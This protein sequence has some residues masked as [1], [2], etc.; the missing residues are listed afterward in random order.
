MGSI[1]E[2]KKDM[3]HGNAQAVRYKSYG[4]KLGYSIFHWITK[5]F[6]LKWAYSL[7]L[8]VVP[9]YVLFR[10]DIYQR[11]KP[12]LKRRFPHD[13]FIVRY[14]R[15]FKYIFVFG[16]NLVDQ[17]AI[18]L[19]GVSS[20]ELVFEHEEEVLELLEHRPV[21]FLMSHVGFWEASMA[22][23]IRFKKKMNVMVS[24]AFDKDKRKSFYDLQHFNFKLIDVSD[25]YGGMIE[26]TNALLRGEVVGV[27]GDRADRW[28]SK[29]VSFLGSPAKFPI[30]AQ[31]L[32]VATGASVIALFAAKK[33]KKLQ[34][35]WK[36]ISLDEL[37][38]RDLTKEEKIDIMLENY[39]KEL[40]SYLDNE[41]YLWFN[42]FDFWQ[43]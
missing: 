37:S 10:P 3:K 11:T 38:G 25:P 34:I 9:Y 8:L 32:A 36:D 19:M 5:Y 27:T 2:N 29:T 24:Q 18:G 21:I 13:S 39:T 17:Y 12:Y 7:L 40:E 20:L 23:S 30:I 4:S 6:G 26:A 1:V 16:Q 33:G 41:P 28:R 15:L 31:Q 42:F 43:T 14:L 35:T 22:G